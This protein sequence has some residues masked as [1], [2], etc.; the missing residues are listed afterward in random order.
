MRI[1]RSLPDQASRVP[2]ALTI[3]KFDGVHRGHQALLAR[4]RQNAARLDIAVTVMSFTPHPRDFFAKPGSPLPRV[5]T[6]RDTLGALAQAGIG[7]VVFQRFD[8]AFASLPPQRFIR[9]VLVDGL[10]VRS[11]LVGD[12]FRF[13]AGRAGDLGLLLS[14][15]RRYGFQVEAMPALL[16]DDARI[17]SSALRSALARAD[18]TLAEQLLGRPYALAGRL[19]PAQPRAI[20]PGLMR[21]DFHG[22]ARS[23][24]GAG[25]F[26]VRIHGLAP[27]P[28]PAM[29]D[30]PRSAGTGRRAAMGVTLLSP[31]TMS[32]SKPGRVEFVTAAAGP[33]PRVAACAQLTATANGSID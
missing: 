13:G 12:D 11:L 17:S 32:G 5:A 31:V 8:A 23:P 28:L 18:F 9:E 2:T 14:E 10:N 15:G 20:S 25:S 24:V 1:F 30:V 3:G 16:H 21:L 22:A 6:L 4:L 29:L 7:R 26:A 19:A 27:L 33:A